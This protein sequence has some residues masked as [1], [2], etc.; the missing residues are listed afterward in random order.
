M[1]KNDLIVLGVAGVAVYMILRSGGVFSKQAAAVNVNQAFHSN[2]DAL[3]KLAESPQYNW[4]NDESGAKFSATG[5]DVRAR[6]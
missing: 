3:L 4:S 5:A 2:W 1:D 6:R